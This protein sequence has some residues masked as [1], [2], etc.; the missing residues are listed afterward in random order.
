MDARYEEKT[1]ESYFNN[2]LDRK[3]SIYFPLGQVQEGV[4]GIDSAANSSDWLLWD[5]FGWVFPRL[6]GVDLRMVADEMEDYLKKKV[7][8]IPPIKVNVLFQYKRPA[9]ISRSNGKEWDHWKQKYYRYELYAEQHD[10]LAHLE[11]SFGAEAI[12]LYAA[13]AVDNIDDLV[14]IKQKNEIIKNT[15]FRRASELNGHHR[16]TYVKSGTYSFACSDPERIDNFDLLELFERTEMS[17]Q[18]TNN[19][20]IVNF[21]SRTMNAME[22]SAYVKTAVE[23]RLEDIQE[24]KRFEL[25]YAFLS[26]SVFREITGAQWLTVLTKQKT[27]E[28]EGTRNS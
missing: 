18:G 21:A 26:M 28:I 2:E 17:R 24:F 7:Q 5:E 15:N 20:I 27:L 4:L 9:V 13:P 12:V 10:L 3:T 23:A 1:F 16:N 11:K 25:L 22:I 6:Q 8:N 14:K 19:K